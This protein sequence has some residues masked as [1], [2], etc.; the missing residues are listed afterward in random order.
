MSGGELPERAHLAVPA[1]GHEHFNTN[2][3]RT[4]V[5]ELRFP[6]LHE[7]DDGK[8]PLRFAHALRKDYPAH[9]LASGVNVSAG[10][11]AKSK[12]H[13]FTSRN[14]LW[15]I[16]LST[17]ALSLETSRYNSFEDF[18]ERIAQLIDASLSFIDTDFFTRVG[19]RY[20]NV[21]P[22]ERQNIA[23]WVNPSL[24]GD[25]AAGLY[26]DCTEFSGSVRGTTE[27]GGFLLQH[28]IG[29]SSNAPNSPTAATGGYG[30]DFDFY[31]ENVEVGQATVVIQGLHKR[32]FEMF[33][34]SLGP[35]ALEKLRSAGARR[36]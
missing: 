9:V 1:V 32:Q 23:E 11:M 2:F 10:A 36:V 28:G 7:I 18:E 31:C 12:T 22:Y 33:L 6:T 20:V 14:A 13:V 4:A 27:V 15:T 30:L 17:Q 26:G 16:N 21:L 25:L 35:R 29:Q 5:C 19:I 34:W 3:I 24:V 8:P